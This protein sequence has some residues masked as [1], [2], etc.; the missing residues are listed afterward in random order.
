MKFVHTILKNFIYIL[1]FPSPLNIKSAPV[2]SSM[3]VVNNIIVFS[4]CL[5]M[6]ENILFVNKCFKNIYFNFASVKYT[7]TLQG[8]RKY[9]DSF[10]RGSTD[11]KILKTA[12]TVSG[13][14]INN[15][16]RI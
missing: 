12:G 1:C 5:L 15:E 14:P 8:F 11:V 4:F 13:S 3:R 2:A 16:I 10:T 7:L 6:C 9:S